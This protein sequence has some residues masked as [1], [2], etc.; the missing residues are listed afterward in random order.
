MRVAALL[1]LVAS[2]SAGVISRQS[3]QYGSWDISLISTSAANGF[4]SRNLTSVYTNSDEDV[5]SAV[6][7][8]YTYK[9]WDSP[10][11]TASCND[12]SFSYNLGSPSKCSISTRS[13][14]GC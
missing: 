7:C 14:N 10:A 2:A 3:A 13:G 6:H 8:T 12:K 1:T 4:R 9:P 11:E 5:I